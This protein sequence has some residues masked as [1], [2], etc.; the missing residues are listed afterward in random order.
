MHI[1]KNMQSFHFTGVNI[2]ILFQMARFVF[3]FIIY[4][5][6]HNAAF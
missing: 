5:V 6:L 3:K 4:F 2:C 1:V